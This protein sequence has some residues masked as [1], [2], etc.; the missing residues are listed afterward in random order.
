MTAAPPPGRGVYELR[1]MCNYIYIYIHMFFSLSLSM[2]I[3]IY[4]YVLY[5]YYICI[6]V[7]MY[8]YIYMCSQIYIYIYIYIYMYTHTYVHS[9]IFILSCLF[10]CAPDDM[11]TG[12]CEQKHSCGKDKP[13]EYQLEQYRIRGCR[14][15]SATGSQGRRSPKRNACFTDPHT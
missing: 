8:T 11:H 15:V 10:L 1:D 2:Y 6:Y 9:Y 12:V 5:M 14:A 7:Y 4:I 3:Y 13:W